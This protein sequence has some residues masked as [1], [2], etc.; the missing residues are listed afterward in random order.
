MAK[1]TTKNTTEKTKKKIGLSTQIFIAL[2]LGALL[3]VVIHYWI[4]SSYIKDTVIVEGVLY[5]IG[6]GFIRLMQMLVVPLVFCSLICGSMAIGDT[7]TL[8]KVGVKT[9]GF[10]LVTTALAVCVA[11]GSALLINPGRGLDMDA[12]QKGTVSSTTEA[13][14]L[15]DTLLNIIPKNPVQSMAN[16]DMLP[17]IV[18]ALF[19]G[20][21]LAKLGTRGSVVAN[22]FSQFNDVM[23]EMTMAIMKIAPIGVF[24]LIARTFATVGFS[25]FAPMLKYMGNVTLALAIQCLVVYQ[26]LLFVFTRLNPFKFIKKF[27]PVMGFAFSTA[28][29]NATIPMSIDTLSKKMGVSKQISSFTI[30]LGATINMDG[31]SIMQGVAVVFIAQAYGIPLTMGNLATV[32]V[33]ATLASIG[34]AG[35]PSVGLV[36]LAMVLNSVGLPTEGIA[37]IMGIDR[38]LDMIRT[39]VNI[40]GDAVCTTIVCHQEGSLNREVFNKD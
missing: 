19:V 7:K 14:S 15:V 18:F 35:V 32:V 34:T 28:T 12:V 13:T 39:A 25:A 5:V 10:Y 26:I 31:T 20:I 24:C 16:G 8:G 38:I 2:L 21:M 40:T 37:L 33:T 36:T 1:D 29:S 22:F 3:G 11:L 6:Q 23:M 4:P 30:P 27:L 9:I 17:I